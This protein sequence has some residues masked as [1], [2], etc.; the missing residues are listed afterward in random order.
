MLHF[1]DKTLSVTLPPI[2]RLHT[3]QL[4][5]GP[6]RVRASQ[7]R[8]AVPP[9]EARTPSTV[10]APL[11]TPRR[12]RTSHRWHPRRGLLT[13]RWS[14]RLGNSSS[15]KQSF[16]SCTYWLPGYFALA[17]WRPSGSTIAFCSYYSSLKQ[18]WKVNSLLPPF[19]TQVKWRRQNTT[20]MLSLSESYWIFLI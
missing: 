8:E 9:S 17:D 2:P 18:Q 10:P 20:E 11:R 16:T 4:F 13:P 1:R 14:P 15:T 5:P 3:R 12:P 19:C 7:E 6:A